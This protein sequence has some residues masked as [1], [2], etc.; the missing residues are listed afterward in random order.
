[1]F[2][3]I[4]AALAMSLLTVMA[5]DCQGGGPTPTPGPADVT[6]VAFDQ[7]QQQFGNGDTR[8]VSAEVDFPEAGQSFEKILMTYT[9]ECPSGG[10]DPYD[11]LAWVEVA[12][13]SS[14]D[15]VWYEVGRVITPFGVGYS[16]T[17]DV[18]DLRPILTGHHTIRSFI[19]TWV[20]TGWLV[21]ISFEFFAGTP[22]HE[23]YAVMPLW[24]GYYPYGNA[25]DSIENYLTPITLTTR[26][27][28]SRVGLR[29]L[30]TGHGWGENTEN[31]AEFCPK[32]HTL[33]VGEITDTVTVWR[34]D[35]ATNS[36]PNQAGTYRY[37]RHG[38]CPGADVLARTWDISPYLSPGAVATLDYDL[39]PYTNTSTTSTYAPGL[40]IST[41]LIYYR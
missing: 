27:D 40:A 12:D 11:R 26:S 19:D 22:E 6:V 39:Q 41:Y 7:V 5:Q 25:N 21:T 23:A 32:D 28:W 18:T 38:W 35:C 16:W 13:S 34:T 8:T 30:A 15:E 37:S 1:M 24:R 3:M 36:A 20:S 14:G 29:V 33:K 9:L 31:C 2:R 4:P 17:S 10:C